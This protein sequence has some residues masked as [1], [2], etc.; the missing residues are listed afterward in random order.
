M[1]AAAAQGQLKQISS[2]AARIHRKKKHISIAVTVRPKAPEQPVD[3]DDNP[4]SSTRFI[5]HCEKGKQTIKW[6]ALAA[7]QRFVASAHPHGRQR[8]LG[9][10]RDGQMQLIDGLCIPD[11]VLFEGAPLEP[12]SIVR[13]HL[14]DGDDVVVELACDVTRTNIPVLKVSPLTSVDGGEWGSRPDRTAF[15]SSGLDGSSTFSSA[16]GS[17]PRSPARPASPKK[18]ATGGGRAGVVESQRRMSVLRE[19][20]LAAQFRVLMVD[21]GVLNNTYGLL[22][23]DEQ[24]MILDGMVSKLW[25]HMHIPHIKAD[26]KE[27]EL[28]KHMLRDSYVELMRIFRSNS[29][30]AAGNSTATMSWDQFKQVVKRCQLGDNSNA[31][32]VAMRLVFRQTNRKHLRDAD[33]APER[34]AQGMGMQRR[35]TTTQGGLGGTGVQ[36]PVPGSDPVP[37]N[38]LGFFEFVEVLVNIGRAFNHSEPGSDAFKLVLQQVLAV[39]AA[40]AT[41]EESFITQM[42]VTGVQAVLQFYSDKLLAVYRQYAVG[43]VNGGQQE[44]RPFVFCDVSNQPSLPATVSLATCFVSPNF[45]R[46][47]HIN[48]FV[49][50][51]FPEL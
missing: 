5:V 21:Q 49:G 46:S 17:P 39:Y 11:Q 12:N 36:P 38:D 8:G 25:T 34:N 31:Q 48:P 50:P 24:T 18:T 40:E 27:T 47:S 10:K 6:L 26:A 37:D 44:V 7:T 4:I 16:P 22:Q 9:R 51:K 30:A 1:L 3:D 45:S 42:Q 32:E 2:P 23:D 28:T 29:G 41:A 14:Q 15:Q 13:D 20:N 33:K 19:A 35:L 43:G